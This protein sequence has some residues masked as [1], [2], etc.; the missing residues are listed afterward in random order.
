MGRSPASQSD[1]ISLLEELMS[2][3]LTYTAQEII[4]SDLIKG[5]WIKNYENYLDVIISEIGTEQLDRLQFERSQLS[6]SK[7]L[8]Y[9]QAK[10]ELRRNRIKTAIKLLKKSL[11]PSESFYPNQLFMLGSAQ[12]LHGK[13]KDASN[14]FIECEGLLRNNIPKDEGIF[15]NEKKIILDSCILN[16][17]RLDFQD[18][19]FLLSTKQYEKISKSSLVWPEILFEQA[20]ASFYQGNY[21]R[22]LG[23]LVTYKSPFFNFI[24]NPE[25]EVLEA[26]SYMEICYYQN[27]QKVVNDFYQKYSSDAKYLKRFLNKFGRDKSKIGSLMINVENRD[28][29]KNKLLKRI[30][31]SISKDL[32]FKRLLYNYKGIKDELS[33]VRRYPQKKYVSYLARKLKKSEKR[34][35][36]L[37]GAYALRILDRSKRMLDKSFQG[38]SYIKLEILKKEKEKFFGKSYKPGKIGDLKNVNF[39]STHYVWEFNGEFWADELGDYVF[40]LKSECRG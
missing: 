30:L 6:S 22:T 16:Q 13:T 36:E 15:G 23:K 38:M 31:H 32:V 20:W 27:T 10:G 19:N 28:A 8:N 11:K 21:N 25:V 37:I 5:R 17:A 29:I 34:Q 9:I 40:S 35:R 12:M 24:F 1:K 3:N 7:N 39:N 26:L 14:N 33:L 18:G 4:R 2:N